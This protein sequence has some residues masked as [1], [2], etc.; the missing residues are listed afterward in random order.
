MKSIWKRPLNANWL[1]MTFR[2][3]WPIYH[4]HNIELNLT[5]I[6][7]IHEQLPRDATYEQ[8]TQQRHIVEI[9]FL[10]SLAPL[11]LSIRLRNDQSNQCPLRS[12]GS[13]DRVYQFQCEDYSTDRVETSTKLKSHFELATPSVE[14]MLEKVFRSHVMCIRLYIRV[15]SE[16]WAYSR[17]VPKTV[18]FG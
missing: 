17:N 11:W 14:V 5:S 2:L 4:Q 9:L 16:K 18:F 15:N 12:V 6:S 1:A 8:W 10:C 7:N 3:D 13:R